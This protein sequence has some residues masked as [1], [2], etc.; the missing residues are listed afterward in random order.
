MSHFEPRTS[1][2][3]KKRNPSNVPLTGWPLLVLWRINAK[4]GEWTCSFEKEDQKAESGSIYEKWN[5]S[6]DRCTE[7]VIIK[8]AKDKCKLTKNG[9]V[10]LE[11]IELWTMILNRLENIC[12]PDRIN[13]DDAFLETISLYSL[14][15]SV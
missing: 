10:F 5:T 3:V 14:D 2:G 12:N 7:S 1:Y 4:F 6:S 9:S 13:E 11:S 8:C 15:K